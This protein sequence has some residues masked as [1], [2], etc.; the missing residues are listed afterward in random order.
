MS[1]GHSPLDQFKIKPLAHF[2][3]MG[4]DLSFTNSSLY[5]VLTI[6]AASLFFMLTMRRGAVVPGRWQGLAEMTYEFVANMLKENVGSEGR[7]FFPFIFSLFIFILFA[8]L[9]GMT[10]YSFTV[11][12]HIIVTFAIAIFIFIGVTIVAFA[13]HGMKFFSFFLPAGTPWFFAPLMVVI[14][15]FAYLARPMSLSIRLAA[16]MMAGHV[17][18]KVLAGFIISMGLAFGWLP[19]VFTIAITGFE[20]FVAM[21]QAYI[22]TILTCVYLNDAIHLH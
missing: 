10:P 3:L 11:T 22:F 18:L 14:E 7:K 15:I 13:I 20:F 1:A 2:E 17:M 6:L 12:S 9:L 4:F 16:N 21:L 8:N 5:M 19:F